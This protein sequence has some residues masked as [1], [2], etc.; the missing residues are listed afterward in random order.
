VAIEAP[1]VRFKDA[2]GNYSLQQVFRK[3]GAIS[4]KGTFIG[5]KKKTAGLAPAVLRQC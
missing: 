5:G 4:G 1:F 3:M 2:A